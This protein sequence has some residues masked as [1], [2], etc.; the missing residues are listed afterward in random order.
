[1]DPFVASLEDCVFIHIPKTGGTSIANA[2]HRVEIMCGIPVITGSIPK[3]SHLPIC[4]RIKE[5]S[6]E[7]WKQLFKFTI[8][9][10]PWDHAVS[11]FH[12]HR[13]NEFYATHA[14]F[15]AWVLSGCPSH[16][17]LDQRQYFTMSDNIMVDY[18]GRFE[19]LRQ[20]LDRVTDGIGRERISNLPHEYKSPNRQPYQQY[21]KNN[22][23]IDVVAQK[24]K[25]LIDHFGYQ[26]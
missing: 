15:E 2:L 18:V 8:V 11:W 25:W 20:T 26:F 19:D 16:F 5:Y 3:R 14:S 12:W 10:N 9:R 24:N 22:A 4:D 21:F 6:D 23:M 1:M 7:R 13:N 17:L